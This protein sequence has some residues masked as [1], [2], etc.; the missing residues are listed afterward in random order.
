MNNWVLF[1][2]TLLLAAACWTDLRRMQIPNRLTVPFAGAGL[3][4]QWM[5]HGIS[6]LG[7]ASV[8]AAAVMIPLI[9]MYRFGG[10]GG[11]D[12]KWFGAFGAWTGP[13]PALQLLVLS[14]LFAGGIA[15][16]LLMLRL[17]LIR[18]AAS[19]MKWPWG[20]HP[21]A[22]GRTAKFPFMLAV[23][24]GFITLLGKG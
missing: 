22:A 17:P 6:G 8:G 9:L 21:L 20:A 2:V 7:Q 5:N 23:V 24:P 15:A 4:Y 10:I 13:I 11:G 1:T 3:L 12:V 16:V 14:I 18:A 19:R